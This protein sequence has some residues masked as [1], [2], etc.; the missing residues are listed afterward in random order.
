LVLIAGTLW[1]YIRTRPAPA[2]VPIEAASGAGQAG[3]GR[4]FVDIPWKRLPQMLRFRLTERSGEMFDSATM[5]GKPYVISFFFANCPTI[6]RE[7][8]RQIQ[9]LNHEFSGTELRFASLTVDP[10]N[11]TAERLRQYASEFEA[12]PKQWLFLT[13]QMFRIREIG[14]KQFRVIIDGVNHTG[15][16]FLIDRW[17]RYRDRFTWDDPR[18]MKRFSEVVREVLAESQ[19]PLE[20]TVH[21]RNVLASLSHAQTRLLPWLYDFQL[22]D[23]DGKEFW[24]RDLTGKVWVASMFFTSCPGIC[25]R[26]NRFLADLQGDIAGRDAELVSISTDPETDS[27][28][29]LRQYARTM[30]AGAHWRFLTG[31]MNYIRRIGSEFLGI[32]A[33]GEHHSSMLVVVDKWG[34]VRGRI[35]WQSEG[36]T[37]RLLA[38][39]DE[40]DLE[41]A[42]V[43][44]FEVVSWPES[45]LP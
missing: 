7:L 34:N 20:K 44:D 5:A 36:A 30:A 23:Q 45:E 24:S 14:E 11:D 33:E 16:L 13:G 22:T 9:R 1:V 35:D 17:G 31:E 19:P 37:A 2:I 18:E 10:E 8:N 6:C 21:T 25:P 38:L 40:L 27:P 41:Q 42:P 3:D 4:E 15:D 12:D 32:A 43:A 28:A 29:I 39:I 26:Q